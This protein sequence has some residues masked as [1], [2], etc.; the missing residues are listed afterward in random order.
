MDK[1]QMKKGVL[2][3]CILH[4]CSEQDRYGYEI[5]KLVTEAFPE[6][7]ESTIYAVLRR[8]HA[9]GC[10]E[11]Y[12]GSVSGGPQRKYYRI[13]PAGRSLLQANLAA[14]N[15]ARDLI[16]DLLKEET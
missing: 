13:T 1:A 11:S 4:I 8:L 10:T 15:K 7:N 14:W 6:I 9:D 3:L 16:E 5:M 2:E 12:T